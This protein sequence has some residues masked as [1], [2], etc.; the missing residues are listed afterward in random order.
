MQGGEVSLI[1]GLK[2]SL[3]SM[4]LVFILLYFISLILYSFKFFKRKEKVEAVE[5]DLVNSKKPL[6]QNENKIDLSKIEEDE[7]LLAAVIVATMEASGENKNSNYRVT[8]MRRL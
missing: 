5:E 8:K 4:T 2:L 7:E 3:V 6:V 1:E